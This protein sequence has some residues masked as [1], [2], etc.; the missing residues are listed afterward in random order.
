MKDII[1]T[2]GRVITS[3]YPYFGL[4]G[5]FGWKA[6]DSIIGKEP[7]YFQILSLILVYVLIRKVGHVSGH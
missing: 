4:L 3:P 5:F 6:Y 2:I 1:D 7:N